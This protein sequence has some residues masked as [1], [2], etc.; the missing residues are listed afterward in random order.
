VE[1]VAFGLV[2]PVALVVEVGPDLAARMADE[3]A[4]TDRRE[5]GAWATRGFFV[6]EGVAHT[7]TLRHVRDESR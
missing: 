6:A 2:A 4:D 3:D 7:C 5:R 1:D